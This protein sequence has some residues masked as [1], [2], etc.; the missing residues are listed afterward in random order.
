MLLGLKSLHARRDAPDASLNGYELPMKSTA[1]PPL[2]LKAEAPDA[3]L[4][5]EYRFGD[6]LLRPQERQLLRFG[7]PLAVTARAFDVLALLVQRNGRLVSKDELMQRVWA[8]VVVED[9]NIAV[10]VA[11]LRKLVGAR[12]IA[13]IAGVGYRFAVPLAEADGAGRE[14]LPPAAP[15][16]P[17]NLPARVPALIGRQRELAELAALLTAQPLVTLCGAAGVGKTH[18]ALAAA[19]QL[20]A[21]FVDGVFWVELAPLTEPVQVAALLSRVLGI[22]LAGDDAPLD[23]VVRKLKSQR[24]LVVLDNA[25][26]LLDETA[27]IAQAL[28]QETEQ[29]TLLVTSQIPLRAATQQVYRLGPLALPAEDASAAEARGCDALQLLAQRAAGSGSSLQWD[30]HSTALAADICR[31]LDGNALAIELAAARLPSLGI[32]GLAARLHQRLSLLAPP[33]QAQ[34]SRHNALAAALDWSH[35]LLNEA[36]QRVFRRLSVFPGSFDLDWAADCLA[37]EAMTSCRVVEVILDLVDRSLV[38]LDR[39]HA[40]RYRLLETGRLFAKDK[41]AQSGEA[42]QVQLGFIHGMCRLFEGSFDEH[43]CTPPTAWTARWAPEIDNLRHAVDLAL[44]AAPGAAIALYASGWPLWL[45]L[46][47]HAEARTRGE[48][49]TQHV[50]PQTPDRVAAR[51]WEG[52]SRANSTE[53]PQ[54]ARATAERAARL[55]E[56]LGDAR[57]Q[58]LAWSEY[59]FN[60]RVDNPDARRAMA[61]AKAVEDPRWPSNVL[62]RGRTT[63]ATLDLTAGNTRSARALLLSVL[64]LCQRDGDVEG[65]L[66]AGT[67]LADVERAAG[68]LDQSVARSEALLP[69]VPNDGSSPAEFSVLGNLIGALVAQGNLTRAQEIVSECASRQRRIAAD[70]LWCALDALA[71]LHGL[72]GDWRRA[73]QLAGAADR[74]YR[75][76]GQESRQPNEAADRE[77]LDA[78]L[79]R[80]AD[81]ATLATW[82]AEGEAMDLIQTW[83]C[84][85]D[86]AGLR[87]TPPNE[88]ARSPAPRTLRRNPA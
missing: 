1:P 29:L 39:A 64:A 68:D 15:A 17:G 69:L 38:S 46:L 53:Y 83:Q 16:A 43:W 70:N 57:G 37:D 23:A 66:R 56:A 86:V 14:A 85:L 42:E 33:S 75:D 22:K 49:L 2:S 7:E 80:H 13:N 55:F 71:L 45:A 62:S 19:R 5:A 61:L 8:G 82:H 81:A 11:Q 3:P 54:R 18:L 76:R 77:R 79:T 27:R 63:E 60:W 31:E 72:G 84:A 78:L 24:M 6:F 4:Q 32:A 47:Q 30:E 34:P 73:G 88:S 36:E 51:F 52:V 67:N 87:F 50:T 12:A 26:H 28:V 65:V 48:L 9:N 74:A 10:Q 35:G 41:L 40:P 58:Y 25:E 20:A 21:R 59:A 44:G